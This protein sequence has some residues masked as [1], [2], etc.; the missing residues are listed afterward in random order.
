M[1]QID[2]PRF[3]A[4]LA[5][6]AEVFTKEISA[7]FAALY[8]DALKGLFI[9][10]LEQGAKSWIRHG[11]HF[12]KPAELL[13]R[14]QEMALA[15]PKALP[16][17]LPEASWGLMLMNH[18]F[19]RYLTRR[20]MTDQ[21]KGDMNLWARRRECLELAGFLDQSRAEDL[22]PSIEE[23]TRM[24]DQAMARILDTSENANWLRVELERQRCEDPEWDR[25]WGSA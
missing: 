3:Q 17:P 9:E 6:L 11:K 8:W 15:A 25:R 16:P 12:P 1:R 14:C 19:W 2:A 10:Q 4:V 20:R 21:F 7:P 5:S 13:E 23:I 24:F 22:K 18:L